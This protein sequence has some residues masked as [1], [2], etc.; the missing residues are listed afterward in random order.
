MTLPIHGFFFTDVLLLFED[1]QRFLR[2]I[3]SCSVV[4]LSLFLFL[5]E[6]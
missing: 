6:V 1:L 5:H 3:S 2:K 4:C